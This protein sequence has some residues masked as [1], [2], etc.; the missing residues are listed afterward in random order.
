MRGELKFHLF[1]CLNNCI[2]LKSILL[3][4]YL[5]GEL[6]S[7]VYVHTGGNCGRKRRRTEQA[8]TPVKMF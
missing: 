3:M 6:Q 4:K 8:K 5:Q 1:Q 7:G 2:M